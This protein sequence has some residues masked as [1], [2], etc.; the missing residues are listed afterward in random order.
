MHKCYRHLVTVL[1]LLLFT[2]VKA[3]SLADSLR[4]F[5]REHPLVYEDAWDLWPYS[6]LNAEGEAVGYNIDLVKLILDELDIPYIIKLKPTKKALEDIRDGRADLMLAMD[7]PYH[8]QYGHFGRSVVQ[9][10]THSLLRRKADPLRIKTQAD[11]EDNHIIVHEGSFSHHYMIDHGLVQQTTPYDDMREA[12]QY[13]H[14]TP[15]QQI[16][17]NTLSL[18]WLMRTLP[19]PDLELTPVK[20]PHGE[21]KFVSYIPASMQKVS[22]KAYK[23][24][25]SIPTAKI[26]AC[27]RGYGL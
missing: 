16:L 5:D 19:F 1:C 14:N 22:C 24:S 7:A 23:T 27:P 12:T 8:Q 9:I 6:F 11:L 15:N 17:W 20:M 25:G 4:I 10:F 21:Y 3:Q 18:R 13:V 26:Q 2:P